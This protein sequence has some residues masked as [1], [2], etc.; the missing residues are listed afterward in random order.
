MKRYFA[1]AIVLMMVFT[2]GIAAVNAQQADTKHHGNM[3]MMGTDCPMMA[4]AD[5]KGCAMSKDGNCPMA[6][7]KCPMASQHHGSKATAAPEK[8]V[9]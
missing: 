6:E 4:K 2:F 7:D 8:N 9:P 5:G 1:T 3:M